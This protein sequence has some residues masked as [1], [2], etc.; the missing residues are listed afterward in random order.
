MSK[1][2]PDALTKQD[3]VQLLNKKVGLTHAFALESAFQHLSVRVESAGAA[4]KYGQSEP[5]DGAGGIGDAAARMHTDPVHLDQFSL[6]GNRYTSGFFGHDDRNGVGDFRNTDSRA[7]TG[8][9]PARKI[10]LRRRE[11]DGC[12]R[13]TVALNNDRTVV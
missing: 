3:L 2:N 9:V 6:F 10:Q 7:V 13:N 12:A 11:I 5:C 4:E 8:T 1:K